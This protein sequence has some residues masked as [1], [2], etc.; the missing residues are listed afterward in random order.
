MPPRPPHSTGLQRSA[1]RTAAAPPDTRS[2]PADPATA[3]PGQPVTIV[4]QPAGPPITHPSIRVLRPPL[5]S[6]MSSCGAV[7]RQSHRFDWRPGTPV[8]LPTTQAS[9]NDRSNLGWGGRHAVHHRWDREQH[10]H[11]RVLRGPR[12]GTAGRAHPRLPAEWALVGET[13]RS[14]PSGRL[15]G[16]HLR[17]AG[18]RPVQPAHRRLR[19]R[20]LRHRLEHHPGDPGPH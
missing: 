12:S 14:P 20:H 13:G 18:V 15:S 17:P 6:A 9:E 19:L 8:L 10:Q 2:P 3:S 1:A 5:E 11:R 7:W 4:V 16:D